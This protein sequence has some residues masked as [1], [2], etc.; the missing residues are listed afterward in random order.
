[1]LRLDHYVGFE[2][3]WS[4]PDLEVTRSSQSLD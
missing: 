3:N 1:M 4:L 2:S